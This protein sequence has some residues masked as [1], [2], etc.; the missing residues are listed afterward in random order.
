MIGFTRGYNMSA[1]L[2]HPVAKLEKFAVTS[3]ST[4]PRVVQDLL[5]QSPWGHN[6]LLTRIFILLVSQSY[7][8][9]I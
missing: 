2:Q 5:A 1:I 9:A 6:I 3:Q 7:F 8:R 4:Y